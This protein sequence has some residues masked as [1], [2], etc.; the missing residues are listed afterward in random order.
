MAKVKMRGFLAKRKDLTVQVEQTVQSKT[1]L[2]DKKGKPVIENGEPKYIIKD[3]RR[4]VNPITTFI[5][6]T[7]NCIPLS[8]RMLR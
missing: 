1:Q 2:L 6:R 8:H 3:E 5:I 4:T 7:N